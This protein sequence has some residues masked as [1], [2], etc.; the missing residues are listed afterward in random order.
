MTYKSS[1]PDS[2]VTFVVTMDNGV[3]HTSEPLDREEEGMS[4][5][6]D[7]ISDL[8]SSAHIQLRVSEWSTVIFNPQYISTVEVIEND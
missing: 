3:T 2:T 8:K 6:L 5:L 4:S 7:A 1:D